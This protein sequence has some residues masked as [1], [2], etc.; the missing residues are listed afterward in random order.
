MKEE[1][2]PEQRQDQIDL[3]VREEEFG[4]LTEKRDRE[5][6]HPDHPTTANLE[7]H[8][9]VDSNPD[10]NPEDTDDS[11]DEQHEWTWTS[12]LSETFYFYSQNLP[13]VALLLPRAGLA[14][15]LIF[16]F[17]DPAPLPMLGLGFSA[18]Q[19]PGLERW[20]SR[21]R[22]FF[23]A[24]GALTR[25]ATVVLWLNVAW[26]VWRGLVLLVAWLGLW[27]LSNQRLAGL[28]GPRHIWEETANEKR[29]SRYAYT[30]EE[31]AAE[32]RA[33]LYAPHHDIP[34]EWRDA[35]RMRIQDAFMF[36]LV[37]PRRS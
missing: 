4:V 37:P 24:D 25:Y 23:G 34:W 16:A 35:T 21:D 17:S 3:S 28:S 11:E 26:A 30:A 20:R 19:N 7:K 31:A 10:S 36:C 29:R 22:T 5:S 33:S 27:I 15:A 14:L 32:W 18:A 9:D 2:K 13:T 8:D 1:K 12:A 6:R